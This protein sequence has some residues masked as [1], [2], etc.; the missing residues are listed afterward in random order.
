VNDTS[1]Y[2]MWWDSYPY[3]CVS[4]H[5]LHPLYLSLPDLLEGLWGHDEARGQLVKEVR[6][7]ATIARGVWAILVSS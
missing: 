1:V 7:R 4:V 2:K 3:S 6:E 5:A